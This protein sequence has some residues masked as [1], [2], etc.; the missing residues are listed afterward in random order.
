MLLLVLDS[1]PLQEA[2]ADTSGWPPNMRPFDDG[3]AP[4][5]PDQDGPGGDPPNMEDCE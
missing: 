4:I 2:A 5:T 3:A 1:H